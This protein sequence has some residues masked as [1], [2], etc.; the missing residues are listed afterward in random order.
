MSA[1]RR[2]LVALALLGFAA[3]ASPATDARVDEKVPGRDS[4]PI[5]AQVLV[6]HCGSLDC[7][8]SSYRN[9]RVYGNEGLRLEAADRPLS[10]ECTTDAEVEQD[11]DSLVGLEPEVMTA[12]VASSGARPERLTFMRKAR[13][14]E[15]H[16][17]GTL[18]K[19]GDDIDDC[20]TSWL[21]SQVDEV[22]CARAL[23]ESTC[24]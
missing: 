1:L 15:H 4:F 23:P 17:G 3:C 10:P 19:A 22:A 2:W 14:T 9:L 12:V 7:H 11:Y 20:L 21:A 6:R 8:G 16:K 13:G 18:M 5:V 24:F